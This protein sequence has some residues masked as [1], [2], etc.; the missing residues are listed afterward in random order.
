MKVIFILMLSALLWGCS[1]AN[2]SA[3]TVNASG[4]H[5]SDWI[6]V[7]STSFLNSTSNC[8][9]CH[10]S[11][12]TGG[13]SGVSCSSASFNGQSCHANGP[14]PIPWPAH[15][16]STNQFNNCTPC[17][18][19]ALTGGAT[20]PA[21]SQ[22]HTALLPGTVPIAGT[23]ISCHG[24]PPIG[25]NGSIFPNLSAAHRAHTQH[26]LSCSVCHAGGG[27]GTSTH[28]TS[29][30]V[31]FSA[32]YNAKAANA[33]YNA[34][35]SC[36]NVSCHGGITTP[37]W[38]G[39]RINPLTQCTICHQAGTA[40][41]LPQA[42]SYYS[43]EHSRHLVDIGMLCT[44]CHDMS[45]VSGAAAHFSNLNTPSFELSPASTMRAPLNFN[46]SAASCSPGTSPPAGSFSFGVC[47]PVRNW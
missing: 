23:C 42:N 8:K 13:I 21:C 22:C 10:G 2:D 17:H 5:P 12:L 20:A 32:A 19:T 29:L 3:I 34:A 25:P 47:H 35:G 11:T 30:T 26:A 31:A 28:G 33:L 15:N 24:A 4:K 18:G 9:D 6:A 40:A 1:S 36:A 7:H 27:S 41:G 45:V 43:G 37:L 16:Q 44:D 46:S 14:H 39:G 38:R